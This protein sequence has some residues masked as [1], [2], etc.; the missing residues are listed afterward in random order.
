MKVPFSKP[1]IGEAEAEAAAKVI[2][3]GWLA[4]GPETAAFEE[5]FSAYI[6][7]PGEH[8]HCIFTNSCTSAL[9]MAYKLAKE[10]GFEGIFYPKNTFCATYSAASEMGLSLFSND[11]KDQANRIYYPMVTSTYGEKMGEVSDF[12]AQVNVHYGSVKDETECIIEDSAH[13]IEPND[14]L[15][16][17]IRCYSFYATKNMTT[18]SGGMF[19]TNDEEVYERARLYWRDGLTTSTADRLLK[20]SPAYEVVCMA[21][22]YDGNDVAAAIGRVQLRRLPELTARRNAVRD[23]YND[24]FGAQWGG[25][26]L[27]PYLVR[28]EEE[29][30]QLI[31][32]LK[33]QG[34]SAA[35]HYPR[36]GWLGVSLPIYPD[37]TPSEV[38]YVATQVL[39]WRNAQH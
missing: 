25:N 38:E 11:D 31:S 21:G 20:G 36:T 18:G 35:H 1:S 10:Q 9:K 2:R 17:K 12:V 22:G 30:Y 15:V 6:S 8:Y 28:S 13:R 34:I 26:H 16:G 27:Y 14:P 32:F 39:A 19:V 33:E 23:R 24:L 7:P 3:S 37:L 5:E 29:V 4:A